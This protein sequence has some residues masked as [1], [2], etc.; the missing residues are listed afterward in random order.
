MADAGG[1]RPQPLPARL[2]RAARA[3]G[4]RPVLGDFARWAVHLAAGL[5]W[6][7]RGSRGA[8]TLDGEIHRYLIH[9]HKRTW[10][11]ERAVEVP[12]IAALVER[13]AGARILE[14]GN[15]LSHYGRTDHAV[16]DKYER[17]PGVLN[18]DVMELDGLGPLDLIVAVSTLEHVGWD[19]EPR[20]PG[21]AAEAVRRLIAL[22]A[23]GGELVITVP[24]GYN[25]DFDRALRTG[26]LRPD[27]AAALRRE[28][29]TTRWR[30]V[31]TAEAWSAPYD[32][33][34]YSARGVVFATFTAR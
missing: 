21:R 5:P 1:Y 7:L 26:E 18:R 15:V 3:R 8:F 34:L 24:V 11:T 31:P 33:L 25:A 19:E 16:V 23:S 32:F 4:I 12:V 28:P 14:V 10:T 20:E 27:R 9:R 30:E 22:L 13:R 2:S 6:T 17:A 29:G